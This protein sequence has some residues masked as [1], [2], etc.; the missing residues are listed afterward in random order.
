MHDAKIGCVALGQKS[1]FVHSCLGDSTDLL[2]F[3]E[4][5]GL[6][7]WLQFDPVPEA[8]DPIEMLRIFTAMST[9]WHTLRAPSKMAS[10]VLTWSGPVVVGPDPV[11][12]NQ[13]EKLVFCDWSFSC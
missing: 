13:V 6:A 7:S 3:H 8:D 11:T 9:A 1:I 10:N 5:H 2:H 12:T 4:A